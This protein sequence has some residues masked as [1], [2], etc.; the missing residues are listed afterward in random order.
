MLLIAIA[1][2]LPLLALVSIFLLL[3]RSV[4][5]QPK[6]SSNFKVLILLLIVWL[7][8]LWIT[9]EVNKPSISILTLRFALLIGSFI[10]SFFFAFSQHLV[11]SLNKK[12]TAGFFILAMMFGA[13]A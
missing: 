4:P 11:G 8:F 3:Y 2:F 12:L 13:S 7:S 5:A 1:Y 10:P 9:Y 6:V